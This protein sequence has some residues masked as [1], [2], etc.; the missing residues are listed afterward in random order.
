MSNFSEDLGAVIGIVLMV[1]LFTILFATAAFGAPVKTAPFCTKHQLRV[2]A[3]E[4]GDCR[5]WMRNA[6][7]G[8]QH[9]AR[10][11]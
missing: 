3:Y 1:L 8:G 2:H 11:S 9:Y 7:G 5:I 4:H 10:K 6:S